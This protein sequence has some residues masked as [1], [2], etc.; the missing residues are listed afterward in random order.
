MDLRLTY[1]AV[2]GA[3]ELLHHDVRLETSADVAEWRRQL[4]RELA[5]LGEV[6]VYCLIDVTDFDVAD[7][8]MSEYGRTVASIAHHFHGV[9]RYGAPERTRNAV[10]LES[11]VF[12]FPTNLYPDRESA[13]KALERIRVYGRTGA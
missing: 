11:M 8:M 13:V 2:L 3:W 4:T 6:P 5:K 10:M 7:A 12:G 1:D 9:V